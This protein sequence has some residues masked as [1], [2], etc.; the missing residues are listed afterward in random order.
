ME[1]ALPLGLCW[2]SE[3]DLR[4]M[5]GRFVEVYRRDLEANADRSNLTAL[6]GEE[7]LECEVR[8]DGVRLG[9]VSEFKYLDCVMEESGTGDAECRRKVAVTFNDMGLQLQCARVLLV[10]VFMYGSETMI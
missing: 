3:E 1:I 7:R 8:V 2:K 5:V 9:H 6:N 4:A 10:L